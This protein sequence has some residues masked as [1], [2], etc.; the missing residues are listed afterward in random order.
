MTMVCRQGTVLIVP[1]GECFQKVL[2]AASQAAEKR[3]AATLRRHACN[4]NTEQVAT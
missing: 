4:E 3:A 1:Q 2:P